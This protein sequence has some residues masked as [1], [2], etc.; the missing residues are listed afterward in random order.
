MT[1]NRLPTICVFG[2]G[3]VGSW[4]AAKLAL[5]TAANVTLVARGAHLQAIQTNGL[6]LKS[7]ADTQRIKVAAHA[8][9]S[10]IGPQDYV[11]MTV[12]ATALQQAARDVAPLLGADTVVV[13]ALNGIPWWFFQG[14]D[15]PLRDVNLRTLDPDAALTKQLDIARVIGCVVYPGVSVPQPGVVQHSVG[16]RVVI[17]EPSGERTSRVGRLAAIMTA[18]GFDTPISD[19]IRREIW[20]KLWGNMNVNPSSLLTSAT[21]GGLTRD[22]L[23]H[24]FLL[25][26]MSEAEAVCQ[27]LG[28]QLPMTRE[29][30]MAITHKL[31]SVKTSMLQDAE[32]GRP[33]E[34]D[35]ILGSVVEI[36]ARLGIAM[37]GL[38]A[39]YGLARV[40]GA[41]RGL[42]T[43]LTSIGE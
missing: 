30:R 23:V 29:D 16:E 11:L 6:T 22:P 43:P 9:A 13:P 12:K 39:L 20:F 4:I 42:Y 24:E 41:S 40:N 2:A 14:F 17:G 25:S 28:I 27:A 37:P 32:R 34:L 21:I 7:G 5:S 33:I 26:T 10:D 38:R 31:A 3:A 35:A 18:A 8:R 1:T 19:N 15:G 36:G